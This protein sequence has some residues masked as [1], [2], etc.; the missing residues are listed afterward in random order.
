VGFLANNLVVC[1]H[2]HLVALT[3]HLPILVLLLLILFDVPSLMSGNGSSGLALGVEVIVLILLI[4]VP[5]VHLA[6]VG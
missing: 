1:R 2:K 6:L 5:C 3:N 4:G